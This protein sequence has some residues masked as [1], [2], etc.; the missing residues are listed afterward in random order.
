[1]HIIESFQKDLSCGYSQIFQNRPY[2]PEE[3]KIFDHFLST[4]MTDLK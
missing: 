1:M 2:I 4:S 3:M